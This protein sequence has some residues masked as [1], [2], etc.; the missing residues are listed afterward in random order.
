[1]IPV[2]SW[3]YLSYNGTLVGLSPFL[4]LLSTACHWEERSDAATSQAEM[5]TIPFSLCHC[6]RS[7][8]IL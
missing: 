7:V 1:M 3:N 4:H 8:A 5:R 6:E 2:N